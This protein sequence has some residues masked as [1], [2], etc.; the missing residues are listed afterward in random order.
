GTFT[1]GSS[2]ITVSGNF[3]LSGGTFTSTSATLSVGGNWSHTD[4]TFAHNSGTVDF[5]SSGA[6]SI[7]ID[8]F[9][10]FYNLTHSGSGTLTLLST[11]SWSYRKQITIS[12][13]MVSNTD[14]TNFPVLIYRAS[15]ADLASGAQ[16]D[17]DDIV[18]T[19]S[20]GT[21]LSHEIEKYTSA[22]GELYA[23]VKVPTLSA[24]SDT[25]LYMYYG[26]AACSSQQNP[27]GVW[28]SNYKGVWHLDEE[29]AGTGNLD[30]YQDAT[31]NNNDGDDYIS[32][33]GQ[34]GQVDG[35]QEFD[36]TDDYIPVPGLNNFENENS[37]FTINTWIKIGDSGANHIMG[38]NVSIGAKEWSA[39]TSGSNVVFTFI[40]TG[41]S[42]V[43]RVTTT[44]P[45]TVDN[46]HMVTYKV[47]RTSGYVYIYVDGANQ[48]LTSNSVNSVWGQ[49]NAPFYMGR[50]RGGYFNGS[51]DEIRVSNTARS[52]DW[53]ATSYNNQDD[54][55]SYETVGSEEI[56]KALLPVANNLTQSDG[57]FDLTDGSLGVSGNILVS[58]GTLDGSDALC[59]LDTGGNVTVSAGTLSA[60]AALDDT[61]F[62]VA[63]NWEISGT[64][65]FTPNSGRVVFDASSTGKTITTSSSGA[66]DFYDV[67]FNNAGGEWT[68]QDEL[69]VNND[70]YIT[71]G[72]L[73]TNDQTLS[74]NA[75]TTINGGTLKTGTGIVTFGDAAGDTVTISSGA[76]EIESDNTATDIVKNAGT[77]TNSG[78]TI[79]Y[80]AETGV[81]TS[82]LSSLS[83]YY[84]LT[85]NS[86]GSAYTLDGAITVGNDLTVTNGTVDTSTN[87]LT[88][89]G[90]L[91]VNGGTLDA[92]DASCDLDIN[93]NVTVSSGTLSAPTVLDDTS[94]T[95]GGNWEI[96]GTGIF[97]PNSGRVLFDAS[98]TGKTITTSS[99]GADDF[100]DVKFNN[101]SGEWT[102]QDAL[103]VSND[104]AVTLGT[105]DANDQALSL[106]GDTTI[107][108]GTLKTGTGII[109]FG[110]AAEDTV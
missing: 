3:T 39:W 82:L 76:L 47:S 48:T 101:S 24:S 23:W 29:Q 107:N 110:D 94:F 6:Q 51:M 33:T 42:Y 36:D 46:W 61:S 95:A 18:F 11:M 63:G 17:G 50:D 9:S 35:G 41:G 60:P 70:L 14:Q 75:D 98:S 80:N 37:T 81:T 96:S 93:G 66:D 40:T 44:A 2:N 19:L 87:N 84:N 30:L 78:G 69:T 21:K 88:A 77:W 59:N 53:I 8:C 86:S 38:E 68:L 31:S 1:G 83:S 74:I 5:N 25:T 13:S 54:P 32:A 55:A 43:N 72:T 108:G 64:G 34:D 92:S 26:N 100:Y 67:K 103:T 71:S 106:N 49:G 109:T 20:N 89:T 28:N 104:I 12:N 58:G 97:T 105:L 4:G 16:S 27:T 15:D 79:T 57:T 7:T 22:T 73:D 102:L 52:E 99:S 45:L 90:N 85:V 62:T 10:P 65:I 91:L 56:A